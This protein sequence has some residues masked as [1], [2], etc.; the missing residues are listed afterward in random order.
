MK[1]YIF[2]QKKNFHF[3]IL[4][5][6]NKDFSMT[7]AYMPSGVLHVGGGCLGEKRFLIFYI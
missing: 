6:S 5:F 2:L 7:I 4:V 1:I 3:G